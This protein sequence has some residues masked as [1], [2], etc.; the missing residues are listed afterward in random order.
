MNVARTGLEGF[1]DDHVDELNDEGFAHV[2]FEL[3]ILYGALHRSL[4]GRSLSGAGGIVKHFAH[5]GVF[6][7]DSRKETHEVLL[8]TEHG[9]HL[10]MRNFL[11]FVQ[12]LEVVRIEKT[13]AEHAAS[14]AQRHHAVTARE[15]G[16]NHRAQLLV[17]RKRLAIVDGHLKLTGNSLQHLSFRHNAGGNEILAQT[18]ILFTGALKRILKR[19]GSQKACSHQLLAQTHLHSTAF[20]EFSHDQTPSRLSAQRLPGVSTAGD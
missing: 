1:G 7:V 18:L 12:S 14:H 3:L 8:E 9:L 20:I 19:V 15:L 6:A 10:A 16:R 17:D 13:H 11:D 5:G 4:H 2:T